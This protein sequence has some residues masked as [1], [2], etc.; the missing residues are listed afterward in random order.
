MNDRVSRRRDEFDGGAAQSHSLMCEC[1]ERS[2][3][4][5]LDIARPELAAARAD[6]AWYVVHA[7]HVGFATVIRHADGHAI[8][9][10]DEHR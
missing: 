2:C 4:L 10:F 6:D 9:T 5:M 3:L 1:P 8:V 7:D